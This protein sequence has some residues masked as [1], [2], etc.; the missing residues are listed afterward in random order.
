MLTTYM[1]NGKQT[2]NNKGENHMKFHSL[3]E[4]T[5]EQLYNLY[6]AGYPTHL[7][8]HSSPEEIEGIFEA[9]TGY[10]EPDE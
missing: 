8:L 1:T 5:Q 3:P 10:V 4:H 6:L 7:L 2:A 9:E